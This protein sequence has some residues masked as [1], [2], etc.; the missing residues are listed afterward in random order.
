MRKTLKNP[1]SSLEGYHSLPDPD[2]VEASDKA[3]SRT[4][5]LPQSM[6]AWLTAEAA[7]MT[8]ESGQ[9]MTASRLLADIVR[10]Y[11]RDQA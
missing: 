1:T 11:Q 5:S 9:R 3:V 2:A 7:R 10:A 6:H 4:Y 8:V